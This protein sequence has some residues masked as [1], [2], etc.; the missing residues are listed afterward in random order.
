MEA[1]A[2]DCLAD[3]EAAAEAA[4]AAAGLAMEAEANWVDSVPGVAVVAM[5]VATAAVAAAMAAAMAVAGVVAARTV[6]G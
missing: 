1:V 5:A 2:A 6:A 4:V 3:V